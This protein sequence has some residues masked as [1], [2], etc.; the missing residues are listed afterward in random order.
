VRVESIEC[1]FAPED[2]GTLLLVRGGAG[3]TEALRQVAWSGQGSVV[4][5]GARPVAW[6]AEGSRQQVADDRLA[7]EG[8]V[9]SE[10]GFAGE[11]NA[12]REASLLIRWQVPLRSTNPP[13]ILEVSQ[14]TPRYHLR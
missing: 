12:G 5:P 14:E 3:P 8:L 6:Q 2:D 9:R 13:G 4:T 1:V 10:L 7:I 11:A